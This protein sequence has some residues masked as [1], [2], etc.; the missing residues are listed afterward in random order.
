VTDEELFIDAFETGLISPEAFHH[1]DHVRL[2]F[3]YLRGHRPL[4]ALSKFCVAL[5]RF[6]AAQGK[7][8]RYHET[9]TFAYFFLINER[10]AF[11]NFTSW[12]QF[13]RNN[14]DLLTGGAGIL[15]R[16][17]AES[18]LKSELARTVFVFPDRC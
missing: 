16:Y 1:A 7:A 13:A 18:T 9:I 3:A 17:Y 4:D 11:G 12:E 14:G 6:A 10:M 8:E 15:N 2:A 5:K